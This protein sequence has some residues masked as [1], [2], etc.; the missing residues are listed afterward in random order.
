MRFL[1]LLKKSIQNRSLKE[2]DPWLSEHPLLGWNLAMYG[3]PAA[4]SAALFIS[5]YLYGP[6]IV[7]IT[8]QVAQVP[9]IQKNDTATAST[10]GADHNVIGGTW[11]E[12]NHE[13]ICDDNVLQLK[14]GSKDAIVNYNE[15]LALG[16]TTVEFSIIPLGVSGNNVG[17]GRHTLYEIMFGDGDKKKISLKYDTDSDGDM[18]FVKIN[19]D[20]PYSEETKGVFLPDEVLVK[21]INVRITEQLINKTSFQ[22]IVHINDKYTFASEIMPI[23]NSAQYKRVYLTLVDYT[24][25]SQ[26]ETAV[27]FPNLRVCPLS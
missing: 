7:V 21:E 24:N 25:D 5:G 14:R 8:P 15:Q 12:I 23:V 2:L 19:G 26:N 11:S 18:E 1:Q 10:G 3:I 22:V 9:S 27:E 13:V 16:N 6:D 4:F 20:L 17:F